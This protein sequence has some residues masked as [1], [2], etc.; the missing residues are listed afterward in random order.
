VRE[1][2]LGSRRLVASVTGDGDTLEPLRCVAEALLG[3][4]TG[5]ASGAH[6]GGGDSHPSSL[7]Q[8]L[9]ARRG[10]GDGE[11]AGLSAAGV[12]HLP[13][14]PFPHLLARGGGGGGGGVGGSEAPYLGL[15]V[16]TQVNYVVKAAAAIAAPRLPAAASPDLSVVDCVAAAPLSGALE[17]VG[18]MVRMGW[19]WDAVRVRGGAYG[20]YGGV[21]R[22]SGVA[23]FASYRDPHIGATLDAFDG[24]GAHV[25][26]RLGGSYLIEA[27]SALADD[28]RK[29]IIATIGR[30]DTP[31]SLAGRGDVSTERYLS[32]ECVRGW[33][34]APRSCARTQP[35]RAHVRAVRRRDG[36]ARAAAAWGGDGDERR[37]FGCVFARGGHGG[38][39]RAAW[40]WWAARRR[41]PS[42]TPTRRGRD[43][44]W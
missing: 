31:R 22:G 26:E 41:S 1:H 39:A 5:A 9:V 16:P 13:H 34:Y 17:V 18:S 10:G 14:W 4:A 30:I 36:G 25:R 20:V 37:G 27:G 19:L 7:W 28:V 8:R 3:G 2:L 12:P 15:V 29:A 43:W 44:R 11:G 38:R 32:G 6:S 24:V 42:T 23:S 33:Q 35:V 21:S 40:W